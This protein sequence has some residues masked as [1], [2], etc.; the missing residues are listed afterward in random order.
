VVVD[1]EVAALTSLAAASLSSAA[2]LRPSGVEVRLD[3]FIRVYVF[4]EG[5][6]QF[7][8][9]PDGWEHRLDELDPRVVD[10]WRQARTVTLP[11]FARVERDRRLLELRIAELF[12]HTDVLLTPTNAC[13]PF[14]AEGPMPTE[15]GG[16]PCHGGHAALL[17][18]LANVVNLPSITLP[19]GF[20]ADGLPVGLLVTA[21]RHR[22]DVCLRLARIWEQH[23][24]WPRHAPDR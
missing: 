1:P 14:A 6:D 19:A 22:E 17:T 10:G 12:D 5:A 4:M 23:A 16:R 20:T 8:D 15:I 21:A 3:D 9:V 24:P 13:P 7:V 2:D 18:M 11:A